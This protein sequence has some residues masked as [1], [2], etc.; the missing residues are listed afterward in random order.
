MSMVTRVTFN[1]DNSNVV[2]NVRAIYEGNQVPRIRRKKG[3]IKL[4]STMG[5]G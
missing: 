1:S 2:T 3:T 5:T 4:S